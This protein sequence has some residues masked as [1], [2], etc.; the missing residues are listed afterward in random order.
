MAG[1]ADD[2]I[3]TMLYKRLIRG[4]WIANFLDLGGR[5]ALFQTNARKPDE[6]LWESQMKICEK[7]R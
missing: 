3:G 5:R 6:D 4:H 2:R 7:A 1:C